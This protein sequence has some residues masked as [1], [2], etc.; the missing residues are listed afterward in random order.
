MPTRWH[1]EC[2]I[3]DLTKT[4][5]IDSTK[6]SWSQF[7]P[8]VDVFWHHKAHTDT[9]PCLQGGKIVLSDILLD[10]CKLAT[11]LSRGWTST[12]VTWG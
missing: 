9:I 2:E 5:H 6:N 7:N 3:E 8:I 11:S 4:K 1:A 10:E 12:D